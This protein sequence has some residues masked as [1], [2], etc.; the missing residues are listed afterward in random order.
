MQSPIGLRGLRAVEAIILLVLALIVGLCLLIAMPRGREASR[1]AICKRNLM[2][3]GQAIVMYHESSGALPFVRLDGT[4]P[5]A[6]MLDQLGCPDFNGLDASKPRPK[7]VATPPGARRV[8][9]FVCPSDP[10]ATAGIHPAPIS[11]RA[12]TGSTPIGSGGPFAIGRKVTLAEVEAADGA[13]FTAAF[14]ERLVGNGSTS[15]HGLGGYCVVPDPIVGSECPKAGATCEKGDAGSSWLKADWLSTLY[16]HAHVP[17]LATSCIAADGQTAHMGASSGH[18]DGVHVLLL[19][20]SVK[21]YRRSI[22]P[23]IWQAL[24]TIGAPP[25]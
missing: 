8:P 6:S 7:A 18:Q 15:D 16:N 24:G 13:G 2:Q 25:R 5:L 1:R 14:A 3:I 22:T 20:G 23:E 17:D 10:N 11:Y 9:G 21:S 4:S 19:D 12:N